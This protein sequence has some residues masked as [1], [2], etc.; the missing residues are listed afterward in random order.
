[1]LFAVHWTFDPDH[2]DKAN[3]RFQETG[4]PPPAGVKMLGR[5]HSLGEGSGFCVCETDDPVA[6]GKWM[7]QWSDLLEFRLQ[8]VVDDEGVSKILA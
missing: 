8:P 4:G 1:M 7:Q 5:W 2:R 6:L 3:A